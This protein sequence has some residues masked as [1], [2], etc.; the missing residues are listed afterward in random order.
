MK[1]SLNRIGRLGFL[2]I[3]VLIA[4]F[5]ITFNTQGPAKISLTASQDTECLERDVLTNA[6]T[7]LSGS[8]DE[9]Q[10]ARATFLRAAD[11]SA[12]CKQQIVSSIMKAMDKPGLDITRDQAS[13][14][15]WREGSMLLGELKASEALDLLISHMRMN[16]GEWSVSMVHQPA[17]G[18]IIEMGPIAIPKLRAVLGSPDPASR[19]YAVYCVAQIGGPSA[20]QAL[21]QALP[22]ESDKCVKRF[23]QASIKSLDNEKKKLQDNGEWLPAFLCN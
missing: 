7:Q 5:A 6:L 15:L 18:G 8:Y 20:L 16:D 23:I 12:H 9:A 11:K 21:K 13:Y 10:R 17:L 3:T 22:S 2:P 19:H 1:S 4:V 14:Y